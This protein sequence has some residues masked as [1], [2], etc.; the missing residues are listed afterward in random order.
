TILNFNMRKQEI[1]GSC[2]LAEKR[3]KSVKYDLLQSTVFGLRTL[4]SLI[5]I[6]LFGTVILNSCT[7]RID[8][9]LDS[10]YERLAV[11]GFITP[12]KGDQYVRLTKTSN[13][14]SN[15]PA[16]TVS[17]AVVTIS[18]DSSTVEFSED[19]N[20]PG[21][22]LAPEDYFGISGTTYHLDI[23]LSESINGNVNYKA[24]EEM[25]H[26]ADNIDSVVVEY[27]EQ[28]ERWM[29]RLY[30]W[31]PPSTDFYMFNGMRN[32]NMITDTVSRINIS[33][34]RLFNGNYTSG[35]VVLVLYKD[36]L[37]LGDTF[38]LILSNITEE[39]ANYM[40]DL[41]LE[42]QPHD[43]MFSG[44]PANVRTNINNNA[45]GYFAAFPSAFTST[46]VKP[47][48]F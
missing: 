12:Q 25:P 18:D 31:E 24:H 11:A 47:I 30:A 20:N 42:L 40:T 39:Y 26:L 28:Y 46:T 2:K 9:K 37:E 22:Y 21:Y 36:E 17:G 48:D 8:I 6:L 15:K 23:T 13:Y 3:Q 33:D 38:T 1:V 10:T 34:D 14:F 19:F 27:N 44:P 29:V 35:A 43:P 41:Q 16:P 45:V 5:I 32:G 4:A 7:K